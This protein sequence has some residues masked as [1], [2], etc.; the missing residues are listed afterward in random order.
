MK[1]GNSNKKNTKKMV[2]VYDSEWAAI[3]AL[4]NKNLERLAKQGLIADDEFDFDY[5]ERVKAKE[6]MNKY[7]SSRLPWVD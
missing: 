5:E 4:A 7:I 2:L 6:E 1:Q 3:Q